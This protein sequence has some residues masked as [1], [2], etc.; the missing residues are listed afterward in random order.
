MA[1][2]EGLRERMCAAGGGERYFRQV[3]HGEMA[4]FVKAVSYGVTGFDGRVYNFL[5]RVVSLLAEPRIDGEEF[6]K[7]V[8][9]RNEMN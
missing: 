1:V 4:G 3:N 6:L 5:R 2:Y 9:I 7:E 8:Y